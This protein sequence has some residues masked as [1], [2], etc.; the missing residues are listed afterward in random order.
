[1]N[2]RHFLASALASV[3]AAELRGV[4]ARA[5]AAPFR[6]TWESLSQ[7]QVPDWFRD[8]KFGI[9]AHWSAQ[10]V[11]EAGRLVRARNVPAGQPAY[12]TI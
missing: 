6:A 2:R 3:S 11:P 7:Y 12:N 5:T 9:W 8:A 1:M 4:P 10:C